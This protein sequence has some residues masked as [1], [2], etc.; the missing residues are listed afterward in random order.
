M[1]NQGIFPNTNLDPLVKIGGYPQLR[2]FTFLRCTISIYDHFTPWQLVAV[3]KLQFLRKH[4]PEQ[5]REQ[6]LN[7]ATTPATV[8]PV[9]LARL[10]WWLPRRAKQSLQRCWRRTSNKRRWSLQDSWWLPTSLQLHFW[11]LHVSIWNQFR[12]VAA[13]K[14]KFL[15]SRLCCRDIDPNRQNTEQSLE[16]QYLNLATATSLHGSWCRTWIK[17]HRSWNVTSTMRK[18][19]PQH[20]HLDPL[21]KLEATYNFAACTAQSLFGTIFDHGSWQL[22]PSCSSCAATVGVEIWPQMGQIITNPARKTIWASCC[23]NFS[24]APVRSARLLWWLPGQAK[25]SPHGGSHRT[26]NKCHWSWNVKSRNLPQHKPGS[27]CKNWWLPTTSQ[28]HFFALHNL[29]LRPF[30]TMAAGSCPKVAILGQTLTRTASRTS[31]EP[32]HDTCNSGTCAISKTTMVAPKTSKTITAALLASNFKQTPLVIA[33]Q[34]M[35]TYK[36]TAS[37]LGSARL[38][39]EPIQTMAAGSCSKVE[40]LV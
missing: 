14:L 23:Y 20:T 34:L 27:P 24:R 4:W 11:A 25:P 39:L 29:H 12:P 18:R 22:S 26:W 32:C 17:C 38:Y 16:E 30:H 1:S 37:F 21:E 31:F 33:G 10:L 5:H 2:S 40:I 19:L 28:L 6:V 15:C 9:R 36:F 7:L 3:P 13:P 35:T 8:A